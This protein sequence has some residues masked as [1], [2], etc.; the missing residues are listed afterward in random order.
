MRGRG[1]RDARRG[2]DTADV[3]APASRGGSGRGGPRLGCRRAGAGAPAAAVGDQ[4]QHQTEG[5]PAGE[6]QGRAG[7]AGAVEEGVGSHP[8]AAAVL[9]ASYRTFSLDFSA[10]T[11]PVARGFLRHDENRRSG[12][13]HRNPPSDA[14]SAPSTREAPP[15]CAGFPLRTDGTRPGDAPGPGPVPNAP[16][17]AGPPG[18]HRATAGLHHRPG[19]PGGG[20][21]EGT[22]RPMCEGAAETGGRPAPHPERRTGTG[23]RGVPG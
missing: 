7:R 11:R 12:C 9:T 22:V 3:R 15:P 17:G 18:R 20:G 14:S 4:E 13:G 21:D 23:G 5:D 1:H 16:S 10:P 2:V 19:A 8:A 6:D